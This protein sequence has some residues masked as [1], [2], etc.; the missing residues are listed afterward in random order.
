MTT[1][2]DLARAIETAYRHCRCGGVALFCPDHVRENFRPSTDTGGHDG[3]DRG[4]RY[5]EWSWDPDPLDTSYVVDYAYL[6]RDRDG[7]MH[8]E[9]DRHVEGLFTRSDWLRLL[10]DAGFV[11]S[12]VP[13]AHSDI[14]PGTAELFLCHKP[15]I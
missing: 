5:L 2:A 3:A 6:L 1:A 13:F 7:S 4:M 10:T 9:H 15:T 12:I 14:E 11:P 8:V